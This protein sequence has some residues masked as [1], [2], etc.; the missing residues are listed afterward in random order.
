MGIPVKKRDMNAIYPLSL[1]VR[2]EC[3]QMLRETIIRARKIPKNIP[4]ITIDN[5]RLKLDAHGRICTPWRSKCPNP[6][7]LHH[8][9]LKY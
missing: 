3:N 6:A 8:Y 1:R 4:Y 5:N 7:P 9:A 2:S